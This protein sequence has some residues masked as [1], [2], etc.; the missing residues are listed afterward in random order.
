MRLKPDEDDV[1]LIKIFTNQ[2][3]IVLN[4][5]NYHYNFV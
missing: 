3:L 2:N 4:L 5:L 1:Y